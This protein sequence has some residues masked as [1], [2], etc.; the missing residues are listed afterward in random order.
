MATTHYSTNKEAPVKTSAAK[1]RI[2]SVNLT[3]FVAV[4]ATSFLLAQPSGLAQATSDR[5]VF[6]EENQMLNADQQQQQQLLQ[7]KQ[8]YEQQVQAQEN[9]DEPYRLYAEKRVEQLQKLRANGGSPVRG[10]ASQATT[11]LYALQKWLTA[12]SE[13]KL[14]EQQHLQQLDKNIANLQT[15]ETNTRNNMQSDIQGLREDGTQTVADKRFQQQM[16]INQFNE[17]QNE[18]GWMSLQGRPRDMFGWGYYNSP[19]AGNMLGRRY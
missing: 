8:Q 18:M 12:D 19:F 15:D 10:V 11:Q 7:Q 14:E 6:Q 4:L 17:E 9:Q 3:P 5:A 1:S 16:Q 13:T 2:Q